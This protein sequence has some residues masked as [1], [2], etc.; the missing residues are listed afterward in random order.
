MRER[1]HGVFAHLTFHKDQP[2][3]IRQANSIEAMDVNEAGPSGTTTAQ[4]STHKP[5]TPEKRQKRL[6][7]YESESLEG[8][9]F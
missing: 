7:T 4:G 9:K 3:S 8:W 6:Y 2:K 5:A 1:K